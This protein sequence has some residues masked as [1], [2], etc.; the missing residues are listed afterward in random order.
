[1]KE[2]S[3]QLI[4]ERLAYLRRVVF[5]AG[6][7]CL[8]CVLLVLAFVPVDE[9]VEATGKIRSESDAYLF[10]P[11]D[12][13]LDRAHVAE[14]DRVV[15]GQSIVGLNDTA[16]RH[17][18]KLVD[19]ALAKAESDLEL[20][21]FALERTLKLPLPR[22][23]W[24]A[25][26]ELEIVEKRALH[27]DNEYERSSQLHSKGLISERELQ[28]AR[29]ARE[30]AGAEAGKASE[31]LRVLEQGLEASISNEARAAVAVRAAEVRR[32][33][34]EREIIQQNIAQSVLRSPSDGIVT[35]LATTRPGQKV[36]LGDDLAHIAQG[37][38]VWVDLYAGEAQTHRIR[39]GQKVVMDSLAF[40]TLRHG[41]IEG[42]VERVSLEVRS[43]SDPASHGSG[44]FRI[45]A[46]I[47]NTPV[48]L[49]IGSTVGAKVILQRIPLWR[50]LLPENLRSKGLF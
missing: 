30:V 47:E 28:R 7:G 45:L 3:P 19:A 26:E 9:R 34:A 12:G 33:A 36:S 41:Y 6:G 1:M 43:G 37:N 8:L 2:Y 18:L 50:L 5:F 15:A 20:E 32:L 46:R 40:D 42:T 21:R 11:R 23:F 16:E 10:A 35:H 39:A 13:V 25:S 48:E 38:P 29:L 4:Q 14:G 49:T 17:K 31:K 24:H 27:A 22:D 44:K